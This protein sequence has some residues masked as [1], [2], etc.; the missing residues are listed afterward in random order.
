MTRTH[1]LV[2][3]SWHCEVCD[4]GWSQRYAGSGGNQ[5]YYRWPL[6]SLL[7]NI[8]PE[9]FRFT[10]CQSPI[11]SKGTHPP[12]EKYKRLVSEI[13][14]TNAGTTGKFVASREYGNESF[15]QDRLNRQPIPLLGIAKETEVQRSIQQ[16]RQLLSC[17]Q[18][19]QPQFDPR[20]HATITFNRLGQCSEHH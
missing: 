20:I 11:V 19:S 4:T 9:P 18:F 15:S 13:S 3:D 14:E 10:T 12:R 8:W 17:D 5:A 16:S 6:W 7:H 2:Y 1:L